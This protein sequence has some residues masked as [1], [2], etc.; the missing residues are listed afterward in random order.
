MRSTQARY[1]VR[2]GLLGLV[3]RRLSGTVAVLIMGSS[4][5]ML[6]IFS[7]V[8][9]NLDRVLQTVRG[10]IDVVVYLRDD[11]HEADQAVLHEDLASMAGVRAVH[12]VS[13]DEALQRFRGEIAGDSELLE[14]LEENPLPASFELSLDAM[15]QDAERLESLTESV[16]RYPGVEEVVAEIEWVR[17]LDRFSSVFM[18]VTAVIGVIVLVSAVF[19]ISNTVRLTVEES[20]EQVEIMKLVGATNAFIR[21]P[22]VIGGALQGAAAGFLA[23]AVLLVAGHFV[24][25]HI[26]G[27]FFFGSGQILGFVVLSTLLGAGGSLVALRRHLRL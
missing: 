17:R 10:D 1:L 3:R 26:D 15:G 2:E 9:I 7:I 14:A 20:A 18:F 11:I 27:V 16:G 8:S 23:M 12:Y 19:V 13:R 6:A 5:L 24:R 22:F 21:T 4:L 25:Q